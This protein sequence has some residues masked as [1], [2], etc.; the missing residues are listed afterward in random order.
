MGRLNAEGITGWGLSNPNPELFELSEVSE[1]SGCTSQTCNH[2]SHSPAAPTCKLIPRAGRL[3]HLGSE[4]E[5]DECEITFYALVM[6]DEVKFFELRDP[7]YYWASLVG[8]EMVPDWAL[9]NLA[10]K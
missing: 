5:V 4:M 6:T 8:V 7:G 2:V 9:S 1:A 3:V 10:R